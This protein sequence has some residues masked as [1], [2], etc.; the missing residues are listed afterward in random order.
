MAF[1]LLMSTLAFAPMRVH[2]VSRVL[3][4]SR[5]LSMSIPDEIST[6][7]SQNDVVV[8]SKS[9]CPYCT[10]TKAL[11]KE[12]NVNAKVLE[13]DLM[14]DGSVYQSE[15]QKLTSQTSVPNV[16][17]KGAHLGGNDDTQR[18]RSSGKLAELL[19]K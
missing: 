17:V 5:S 13:L 15:L 2:G 19:A 7:I 9:Y 14:A 3:A 10:K 8:F 1:S 6:L 11:F 18:A 12:M 16:F 4:G